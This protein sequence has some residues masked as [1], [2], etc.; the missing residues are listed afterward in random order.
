MV[1]HRGWADLGSPAFSS[2]L[3]ER[4]CNRLEKSGW[5]FV[6]K[7]LPAAKR[8]VDD[9]RHLQGKMVRVW[10]FHFARDHRKPPSQLGLMCNGHL[11]G[12]M[13]LVG[14]F[15]GDIDLRTAAIICPGNP[16][17]NPLELGVQFLP[18]LAGPNAPRNPRLPGAGMPR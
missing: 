7:S 4:V 9:D 5:P 1:K 12:R 11:P 14:I 2:R 16:V 3:Q 8:T 13:L 6:V 17:T 10:Q 15:G 18:W